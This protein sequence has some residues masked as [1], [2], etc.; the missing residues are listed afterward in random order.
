MQRAPMQTCAVCRTCGPHV[1]LVV[2]TPSTVSSALH[3][4]QAGLK[5]VAQVTRVDTPSTRA[6]R[7]TVQAGLKELEQVTLRIISKLREIEK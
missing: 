4:A 1:P 5:E 3:G 2:G 6:Q 7:C